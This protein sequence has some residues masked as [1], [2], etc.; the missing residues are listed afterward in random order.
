MKAYQYIVEKQLQWAHNKK[1]ILI[2][3]GIRSKSYY[4]KKLE[5][6]LFDALDP[7]VKREFEKGDGGELC[8]N[9]QKMCA[10]HSSSALEINI[11]YYWKRI[12][13]INKIA[14]AC[15]FCNEDNGNCR[16]INFEY[17]CFINKCFS[18]SPNIDVVINNS[19]GSK[20]K[21][22]AVE[23]KFSEA[24]SSR[25][26]LGL[27]QKYLKLEEWAEMPNL[28]ELAKSISPED[29]IFNYLHAA[30]LIKHILGLTVN[31]GK[32][33]FRL[34]YLWYDC[35]G[36]EGAKH[37]KEIENFIKITKADNIVFHT[38]SYQELI[39]ALSNQNRSNHESYINYISS[40]YL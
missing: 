22:F 7:D 39:V 15:G 20:V 21:V 23:C 33:G 37:K 6:N 1:I 34:L 13:Q 12:N 2:N 31:C 11:F 3:N 25:G 38:L 28:L 29:R 4:T 9:P 40:R 36:E 8:G 14:H 5:D 24:Y 27:K 18:R 35:L 17:K 19:L 10:L 32:D 16:S 30:Q 26:H